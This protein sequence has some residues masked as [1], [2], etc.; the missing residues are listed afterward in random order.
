MDT[1]EQQARAANAVRAAQKGY[2]TKE[3]A[4]A[5][6]RAV[7][8]AP[9]FQQRVADWVTGTLGPDSLHDDRERGHRFLE[10][11]L[12]LVQATGL[13]AMEAHFLVD[14][15]FHRDVGRVEQEVGGVAVT[16]AALCAC[17]Q[18]DLATAGET[19]LARINACAEV[20]RAKNAQKPRDFSGGAR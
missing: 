3:D 12:E 10:E 6:I 18:I 15:V 9:T 11:A 5:V 1:I 7:L 4:L 14:Y 16:L 8:G 20:I 19:E 13:G 2:I 17:R